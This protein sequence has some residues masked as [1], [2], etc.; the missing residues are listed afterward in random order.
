MINA[1]T[2][3]DVAINVTIG[4]LWDDVQGNSTAFLES[5]NT[6]TISQLINNTDVWVNSIN[7]TNI[8]IEGGTIGGN[9]SCTII[10]GAGGRMEIC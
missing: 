10:Y 9:A 7:V 2:F 6:N 8:T 4:N 3:N 1:V 5:N